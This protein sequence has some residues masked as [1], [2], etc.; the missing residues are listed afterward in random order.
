MDKQASV[1]YREPSLNTLIPLTK[2]GYCPAVAQDGFRMDAMGLKFL[3]EMYPV[4]TKTNIDQIFLKCIY[5]AVN[6]LLPRKM[7]YSRKH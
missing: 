7:A 6:G 3:R 4:I 2:G 1:D 5:F